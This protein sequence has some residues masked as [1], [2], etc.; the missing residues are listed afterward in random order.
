MVPFPS[1]LSARSRTR[2]QP[3]LHLNALTLV[4][5][6][7]LLALCRIAARLAQWRCPPSLPSGYGVHPRVYS[8]A[9]LLL[10]ALLLLPTSYSCAFNASQ[11]SAPS[12]ALSRPNAVVRL[13]LRTA[14]WLFQ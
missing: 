8:E 4:T 7:H 9:S 14:C 12:H 3:A 6:L 2:A 1:H 11:T 5:R 10:I 13:L